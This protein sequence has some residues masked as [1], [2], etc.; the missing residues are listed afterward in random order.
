METSHEH[1]N[2][3]RQEIA[4]KVEQMTFPDYLVQVVRAIGVAAGLGTLW[5]LELGRDALFNALDGLNIKPHAR[6]RGSA[7][8]PGRP[9]RH[10]PA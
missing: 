6:R 10:T 1:G 4:V 7:F 2:A 5:V 9:R 3:S 8:P